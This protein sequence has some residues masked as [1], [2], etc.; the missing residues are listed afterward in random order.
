MVVDTERP[1]EPELALVA[2][3]Q[4]IK[5]KKGDVVPP[6]AY[7][8]WLLDSK[9]EIPSDVPSNVVK[10][11]VISDDSSL[12]LEIDGSLK[13]KLLEG[14]RQQ[15]ADEEELLLAAIEIDFLI[16]MGVASSGDE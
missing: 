4:F 15:G 10:I 14:V 13:D 16:D 3:N 7:V 9:D 8:K 6:N 5:A 1:Q 11:E 2:S 12:S